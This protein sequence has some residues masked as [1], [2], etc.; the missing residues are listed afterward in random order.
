MVY[1]RP[2][3]SLEVQAKA[4]EGDY[5][6]YLRNMQRLRWNRSSSRLWLWDAA[7]LMLSSPERGQRRHISRYRGREIITAKS[8]FSGAGGM[9]LEMIEA[10]IEIIESSAGCRRLYRDIP[11]HKI[12]HHC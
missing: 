10:G 5:K 7:N 11:M 1:G 12:Q 9:D 4:I 3:A 8:Y 6:A 2:A